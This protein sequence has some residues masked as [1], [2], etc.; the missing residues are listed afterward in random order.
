MWSAILPLLIKFILPILLQKLVKS[1]II[2]ALEAEG[3]KT[4]EDL[5]SYISNLKTYST[6][7]DFPNPP[8]DST[9]N[10]LTVGKDLENDNFP[11]GKNGGF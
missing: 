8:P 1:G 5:K 10:N 9:P 2:T 4:L 11:N 6:L 7:K 3:I